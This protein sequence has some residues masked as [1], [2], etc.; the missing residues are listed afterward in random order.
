[1]K[2]FRWEEYK[3]FFQ[4][5]IFKYLV[6]WFSVV[7]VIAVVFEQIPSPI[8]VKWG[9]NSF[10]VFFEL[11]FNWQ[12][13]W[14]SSFFFVIALIIYFIRCPKF[15]KKYNTFKDYQSYSHDARWMAWEASILWKNASDPQKD[16][17]ISR[18]N[19]KK[20]IEKIHKDE[21]E[22]YSND[23]SVEENKQF[24]TLATKA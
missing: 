23:P 10:D 20:F 9:A 5:T 2:A 13:L 19:K 7:P 16:K 8:K 24:S 11:P 15:I 4:I 1:M 22:I 6:M 18:L 17:L 12:I 3:D 14:I 21:N